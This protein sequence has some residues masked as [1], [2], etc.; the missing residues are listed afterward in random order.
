M[1]K[2]SRR[3]RETRQRRPPA[4]IA[5]VIDRL[6]GYERD[7]EA[8]IPRAF[9]WLDVMRAERGRALPEWPPW[10]LLPMAGAWDLATKAKAVDTRLR[11]LS[12]SIVPALSALYAWR[13]GKTVWTFDE[14]L[15]AALA[16]TDG[17]DRIPGEVLLSLP[18]W[19]I[20]VVQPEVMP[21]PWTGFIAHLEHDTNTGNAELRF[22]LDM[23]DGTLA[24]IPVIL[25]GDS[26][27]ES[28]EA[29]D[30]AVLAHA[31]L[32]GA[33]VHELPEGGVGR[34]AE[35]LVGSLAL[36][37]YICTKAADITEPD[38][39]GFRPQ[40]RQGPPAGRPRQVAVGYRIGTA[41][42]SAR[43]EGH[44]VGTDGL[45]TARAP[46][47][48]RAHWHTYWTGPR[49]DEAVRKR[50]LRWV[51]PVTV[52]AVPEMAAVRRVRR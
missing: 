46:H 42:R 34:L 47:L 3:K 31:E 5:E 51:G 41:L 17:A 7:L 48:R 30:M 2:A 28:L 37:C 1:G 38:D 18:E 20:Y 44:T 26:L 21:A 6:V 33:A 25:S 35:A 22:A 16:D 12:V 50:E 43:S 23:R 10:C 9:E 11:P 14:E 32:S 40:R 49:D 36:V 52:G 13:Q 4:P 39:P 29:A 15:A 8:T 24:G 19:G 27:V 45:H